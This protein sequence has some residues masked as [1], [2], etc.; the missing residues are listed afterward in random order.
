MPTA[1]I[2]TTLLNLRSE[3]VHRLGVLLNRS[4]AGHS[5]LVHAWESTN[6]GAQS[7]GPPY[8]LLF[9]VLGDGGC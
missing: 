7:G 3:P 1:T 2:E 5:A 6:A 4:E 8:D 9:S